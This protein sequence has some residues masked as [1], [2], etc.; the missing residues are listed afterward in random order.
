M[1][2]TAPASTIWLDRVE[3]AVDLRGDGDHPDGSPPGLEQAP[4]GVT[5]GGTQQRGVVG[6]AVSRAQPR[7]FQVDAGED[8]VV[9]KADEC[10]D[11]A[12]ERVDLVGDQAGHGAWWCRAAGAARRRAGHRAGSPE[13]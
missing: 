5:V 3:A 11:L 2:A 4:D 10:A 7:S 6:A 1:A 9:D 13:V 8:A 12:L